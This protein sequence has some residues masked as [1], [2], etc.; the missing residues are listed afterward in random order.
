VTSALG[1][2]RRFEG[3]VA[4]ISG[5]SSGIG[6][7]VAQRLGSEGARLILLATPMDRSDLD[8]TLESLRAG[9]VEVEGMTADIADPSTADAAVGLATSRFGAVDVVSNIAG[10]GFYEPFLDHPVEHLDRMLA[11]NVRGTFALSQAAARVMVKQRRGAIVNTTSV[12][13]LAAEEF[14]VGYDASKGA[15]SAMTRSLAVDL[16][17]WGIRVNAVAPGWVATRATKAT[18]DDPAQWSKHRSRIPLDRAGEPR[19]IAAVHAFLASDDASFVTGAIY[20]ADGGLTA[21]HRYSGWAAV[22]NPP[23]GIGMPDVPADPRGIG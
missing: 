7:A 10:T 11:V 21:G 16:A 23:P 1:M 6:R 12:T 15:V 22:E 3:R 13:S 9:G 8:D 4:I 17:P 5:G 2:P 19:E 14:E 18:R 20:V